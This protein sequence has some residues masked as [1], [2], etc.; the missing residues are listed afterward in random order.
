MRNLAQFVT[1]KDI[2]PMDGKDRIVDVVFEELGY[3]CIIPKK[4]AI[5]GNKIIFIQEGAI[6]PEEDKWEF[7]RKRCYNETVK[8]FVI[9]PMTM[10]KKIDGTKVKSWGLGITP[11]DIGMSDEDVKKY[12]KKDLTDFLHIRKYE[13]EEDASPS[14]VSPIVKF[15]L[16]HKLTRWFAKMFFLKSNEKAGFPS[17]LI[18]KSDETSIQNYKAL[19]EKN[20][21]ALVY[22]TAKLEGQ[23]FTVIPTLKRKKVDVYVCSRNSAYKKENDTIFWKLLKEYKV[24]EKMEKIYKETGNLY[25]LQGEQVGPTIQNNIYNFENNKWFIFTVKNLFTGKQLPLEEAIEVAK[26]FDIDFVPILEKNIPL[27]TIMPDIN[28]AVEYAEAAYWRG[29][30]FNYKPSNKEK[31]WKDYMQHEGVVVRSMDYDKDSNKGFSF[32]VKN[33]QYQEKGL[34]AMNKIA[35]EAKWL[36]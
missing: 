6:L 2:I 23:S 13:P 27:S 36:D 26:Q 4:D 25:I 24:K 35:K 34:A 29:R 22:T 15:L 3:E 10:G 32:K 21:D 12:L 14:K 5:I 9:K 19:L 20:K 30:N 16:R 33:L 28:A 8:G 31:L 11:E 18:S 17:E 7:L 1:I